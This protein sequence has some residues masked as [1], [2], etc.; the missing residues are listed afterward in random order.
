M[1]KKKSLELILLEKSKVVIIREDSEIKQITINENNYQIG[2]IHI[3]KIKTT[4][5]SINAA[6]IQIN[7]IGKNGFIQIESSTNDQIRRKNLITER[8]KNNSQLLVQI[9]REPSGNKGPS[10]SEDIEL[11]G[12]YVS[13]FPI[14][15]RSSPKEKTIC[16]YNKR[17]FKLLQIF[18]SFNHIKLEIKKRALE[19]D[20]KHLVKDFKKLYEQ[21][22]LIKKKIQKSNSPRLVSTKMDFSYKMLINFYKDDVRKIILDSEI[23]SVKISN[24]LMQWQKRKTGKLLDIEYCLNKKDVS[25]KNNLENIF[26]RIIQSRINLKSGASIVIEKTEA[27]TVIDVNSGTFKSK[28]KLEKSTFWINCEAAKEISNQLILRNIGGVVIVDFIDMNSQKDQFHLL[29]YF[30]EFLN[31]DKN[32]PKIIQFSEIGLVELTRTRKG[33]NVYDVFT[34]KCYKCNSNGYLFKKL[35]FVNKKRYNLLALDTISIE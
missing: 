16:N 9:I 8:R 15:N 2:D 17:Y 12:K 18:L 21:W 20:I 30:N 10:V 24:I 32:D 27:L 11:K 14:A 35:N 33:K 23:Q 26:R 29:C 6:F 13:L 22:S 34:T 7:S 28:T 4:L 3:G 5:H 25:K 31:K 19:V 1:K